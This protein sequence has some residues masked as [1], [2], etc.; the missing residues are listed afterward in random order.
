M[1]AG[2]LRGRANTG[3]CPIF[4]GTEGRSVC[5]V[6]AHLC[7]GSRRHALLVLGFLDACGTYDVRR[8]P[9][10]AGADQHQAAAGVQLDCAR[11]LHHGGF[12]GGYVH[13]AQRISG[14]SARVCRSA[15]LFAEL[16]AGEA[17]S[18]HDRF[19]TG[20]HG[21]EEPLARR[22]RRA[23]AAAAMGG[24]GAQCLLAIAARAASDGGLFRE[25]LHLQGGGEF[26][27]AVARGADGD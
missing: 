8:E 21:R 5:I 18:V 22:L 17:G 14:S 26:A 24:G 27:F 10:R 15:L 9:G 12:C 25:V 6:A 3:H 13:G 1:D 16:R 20:R 11:R 2:R 7:D 19:A 4:R 23:F